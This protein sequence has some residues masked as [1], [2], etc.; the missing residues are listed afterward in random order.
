[1]LLPLLFAN[2]IG[3][4][5]EITFSIA[6]GDAAG[7]EIMLTKEASPDARRCIYLVPIDYATQPKLDK[8][9]QSFISVR[10]RSGNLGIASLFLPCE[11]V[12]E[13]FYSAGDSKNRSVSATL[14]QTLRIGTSASL[15]EIRV[16][17]KLRALELNTIGAARGEHIKLE[18][19]FNMLGHPELRAHYD[20]LLS[21][22]EIPAVFPT[23]E[24]DRLWPFSN[25]F[26]QLCEP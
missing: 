12:R 2:Y 24:L 22:P 21:N 8:H 25:A 26:S 15:A 9:D 4:G 17:F 16:A 14:Y 11:T 1:V 18:R 6:T 5:D 23:A 3:V 20:S 13:Y 7:A 10:V 19:A